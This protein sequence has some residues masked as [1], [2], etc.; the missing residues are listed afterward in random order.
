ML[1]LEG[2]MG[3]F[4]GLGLLQGDELAF[5][6]H[7][8]AGANLGFTLAMS[9]ITAPGD[10]VLLPAPWFFNHPMALALRG[11]ASQTLPCDVRNGLLPDPE[12]AA[13]LIG[14]R[15]RAIVLVTP[16]NPTGA[17]MPPSLVARFAELCRDRGMWLVLDETYRDFLPA[18]AGA[19]HGLFG[20]PGWRDRVIQLGSFSKAYGIPGHRTGAVVAGPALRAELIK[21]V[22]NIQ[23]CAPRPP[24][25]ALAW[26]APALRG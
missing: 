11:V 14:A 20:E 1:A 5:V 24:Q 3:L 21:A 13:A 9:A 4:V 19:P 26:A 16:N 17:I 15:T 23:I 10:S 8:T 7:A 12:R 6:Q 25:A 22:D 18:E 2:A